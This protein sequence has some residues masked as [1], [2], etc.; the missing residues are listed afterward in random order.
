MT[1]DE[2]AYK[3]TDRIFWIFIENSHP[4]TISDFIEADPNY[5]N[6]NGTRNTQRGRELFEELE[7]FVKGIL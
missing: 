3:I 7:S 5:T 4:Q 6:G 2:R 1:T